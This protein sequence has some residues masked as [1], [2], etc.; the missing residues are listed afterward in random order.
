MSRL[1]RR[2]VTRGMF[3][4]LDGGPALDAAQIRKSGPVRHG[5]ALPDFSELRA[6]Q[7]T[8]QR[9]LEALLKDSRYAR[10]Q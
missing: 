5:D 7:A 8:A 10:L 9:R 4:T 2:E 6:R 1:D 3:M